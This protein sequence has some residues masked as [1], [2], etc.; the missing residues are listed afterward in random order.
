MPSVRAETTSMAPE[1]LTLKHVVVRPVVLPLRR[2]VV[3]KVGR[4]DDGPLVL[5][6]LPTTCPG[7]RS[8]RGS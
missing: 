1:R 5:I 4:F 3:S 6:D 2:P 8:S 7:M